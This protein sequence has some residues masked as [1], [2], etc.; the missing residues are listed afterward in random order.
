M[1]IFSGILLSIFL[2][3][4]LFAAETATKS[5]AF[6]SGC[7]LISF[8]AIVYFLLMRPQMKRNKEQRRMLS[9]ITR[10]DEVVTTGGIVGKIIK[11][12][13]NYIEIQISENTTIKIQK[14]AVSTVLPK[15]SI[16]IN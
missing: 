11:M 5:S 13:E 7:M 3:R 8:F 9:G 10:G 12:G 1:K 14:N 6:H 2:I 4:T 15:G 16:S